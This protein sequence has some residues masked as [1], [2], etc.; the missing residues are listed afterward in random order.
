[1]LGLGWWAWPKVD[2][3]FVGKWDEFNL[4][5]GE[6]DTTHTLGLLPNGR[7]IWR[8]RHHPE[9]I[10][11]FRWRVV[12][13]HYETW[14]RRGKNSEEKSPTISE[15]PAVLLYRAGIGEKN[16]VFRIESVSAAEI[17]MRGQAGQSEMITFLRRISE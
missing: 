4:L 6:E 1:V 3:R 7:G 2:Q 10:S 15:W 11:Y 13:D 9:G 12:G 14:D 8:P 5:D 17:R 16:G